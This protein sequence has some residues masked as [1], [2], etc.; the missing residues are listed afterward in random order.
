[1]QS[2]EAECK[3]IL[4]LRGLIYVCW[5]N[6]FI[7]WE[8]WHAENM[9]GQEVEDNEEEGEGGL[10]SDSENEGVLSDPD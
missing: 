4:S 6:N 7:R 10:I 3:G 9:G 2:G 8:N 1:M 5:M